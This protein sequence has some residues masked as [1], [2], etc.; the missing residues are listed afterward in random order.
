MVDGDEKPSLPYVWHVMENAN[1]K[2]KENLN[3]RERNYGTVISIINRRWEHQMRSSLYHAAY[4]L[5]PG[6]FYGV[7]RNEVENTHLRG[8]LDVLE[9]MVPNITTQDVIRI[10]LNQYRDTVDVFGR[11]IARRQRATIKP[12]EWWS[13]F[14][15]G[16]Y[17]PISTTVEDDE[18]WIVDAGEKKNFDDEGECLTWNE[19]ERPAFGDDSNDSPPTRTY[20]RRGSGSGSTRR[21]STQEEAAVEENVQEEDKEVPLQGNVTG[22]Q[23][24]VYIDED[25]P[26]ENE[27]DFPQWVREGNL[28]YDTHVDLI[29]R[30]GGFWKIDKGSGKGTYKNI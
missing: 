9:K 3:Y 4:Y 5:N 8:F 2:I 15:P 7:D 21:R 30:Y 29:F 16:F 26:N 25:D 1:A 27:A 17:D 11:D 23:P 24:R 10:Q 20:V 12:T 22:E 19:V 28:E 14:G 13:Y 6:L 18:E